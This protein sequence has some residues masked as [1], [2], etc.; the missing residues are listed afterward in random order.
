M[1]KGGVYL[2]FG[3]S[4]SWTIPTDANAVGADLYSYRL[5][6]AINKDYGAIRHVNRGYGGVT[7]QNIV[8]RMDVLFLG[9]NY[10]LVTLQ[11]GMNDCYNNSVPVATYRANVEKIIDKLKQHRPKCEIILCKIPPTTDANRVNNRPA[12]NTVIDTIATNKNVFVADFSNAYTN[13]Y[14][15]TTDGIHPGITGHRDL[16]EILYPVV[17]QTQFVK[18]L[19]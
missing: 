1:P 19:G 9:I 3:D 14:I 6:N 11:I 18:S 7:S 5:W 13:E 15:A 2:A 10:D 16:F 8:E 4:I 17:K 12:Y